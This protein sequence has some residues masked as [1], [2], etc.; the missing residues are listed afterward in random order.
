MLVHEWGGTG[1]DFG[2]FARR[3]L[4]GVEIL[5]G[6]TALVGGVGLIVNGLG[7]QRSQL[8]DTP[9]DSLVLPGLLLSLVVGGSMLVAAAAVWRDHPRAGLASIGAGGIMLGWIAIE[10]LMIHDGRPLQIS[11]ALLSLL[12]L[13]LGWWLGRADQQRSRRTPL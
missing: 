8:A 10:S 6:T 7:I 13:A 3:V 12:T 9:F 4:A 1:E 11:V 2:R 5:A